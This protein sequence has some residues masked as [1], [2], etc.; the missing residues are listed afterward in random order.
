MAS[1]QLS[2]TH[3]A[4]EEYVAEASGDEKPAVEEAGRGFWGTFRWRIQNIYWNYM[5]LLAQEGLIGGS[6]DFDDP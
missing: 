2:T 3:P 1:T 5:G 6:S 4:I